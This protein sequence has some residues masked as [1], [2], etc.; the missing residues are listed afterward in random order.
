VRGNETQNIVVN[1]FKAPPFW[2]DRIKNVF[3]TLSAQLKSYKYKN[4]K[5]AYY[6]KSALRYAAPKFLLQSYDAVIKN[7][8]KNYGEKEI[9][10]R[11]N[12]YN[13][14]QNNTAL[15]P[16]AAAL[17]DFTYARRNK[18]GHAGSMSFFD[19]YEYAR[20]FPQNLKFLYKFGDLRTS[21]PQPS[22]VKSRPVDGDN[23]NSVLL[24]L[25]KMRHFMFLK[26]VKNFR[27]KK[28]M[29]VGRAAVFQ[30]HRVKFWEMY[31]GNPMC[32]LG[33]TNKNPKHPEWT[34]KTM[35]IGG[36]LDYKFILCLEGNDVATNLKWVMSSNSL[37]VMPRPEVE[38]WFM[39]GRLVPDFHYVEIKRDYSDLEERLKYYMA[40]P[41]E[42]EK[43]IKNAHDYIAQFTD[44]KKED[45][46]SLLVLQ[47]YFSVTGQN[48]PD[49][50]L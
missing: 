17:K 45:L 30:P 24:K 47:K 27:D 8:L 35:S 32:D 7:S 3:N 36:H 13:K 5:L 19:V 6:F 50:G 9:F 37:A 41:E 11:V 12:Y 10:D 14:L 25:N 23:K 2:A 42:A 43:I 44:Q 1:L 48:I 31:F 26:D 4:S 29:L 20:R 40:R 18:Y 39:E 22:I 46:I 15:P 49:I 34:K 38:S 21:P 16:E 28:D 33:Q